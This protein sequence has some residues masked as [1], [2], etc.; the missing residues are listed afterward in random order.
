MSKSTEQNNNAFIDFIINHLSAINL[1]L[2]L[3]AIFMSFFPIS[4][5]FNLTFDDAKVRI[6]S[7]L[8]IIATDFF[9]INIGYLERIVKST[10]RFDSIVDNFSE[11]EYSTEYCDYVKAISQAQKSIFFS[12]LG[13]SHFNYN[14]ANSLADVDQRI[15]INCVVSDSNSCDLKSPTMFNLDIREKMLINGLRNTFDMYIKSIR[16]KRTINVDFINIFAHISYF[17]IDYKEQTKYSFIEAKHYLIPEKGKNTSVY[18]CI[19]RPGTEIYRY[20]SNQIALLEEK[21]KEAKA[22]IEGDAGVTDTGF[23]KP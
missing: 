14:L 5:T 1:I 18:Y 19:A 7:L 21:A 12:G 3:I 8:V 22:K 9:V 20:Y 15:E 6:I 13:M 4:K 10:A 16:S 11:I 17:A 23:H 2:L